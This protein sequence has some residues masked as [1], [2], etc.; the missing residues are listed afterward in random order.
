MKKTEERTLDLL[1]RTLKGTIYIC[2][3]DEQTVNRFYDDAQKQGYRFGTI[4]PENSPRDEIISLKS[5]R[6]LSHVGFVGRIAFQCNG[7][8]SAGGTFHRI[9]YA[10]Y[11]K[12][13]R[14]IRI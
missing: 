6:Q 3:K 4:L 5:G 7:G 8:S 1:R 13:D 10:A 9:D 2:L 14:R 11:I 12:G